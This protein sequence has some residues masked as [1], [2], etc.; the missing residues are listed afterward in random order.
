MKI[1]EI[2][3]NKEGTEQAFEL[4]SEV[5]DGIMPVELHGHALQY[6]IWDTISCYR[7]V[8]SLL[9]DLAMRPEF[10]H[11]IAARFIEVAEAIFRQSEELDLLDPHQMLL[12]CTVACSNFPS[13]NRFLTTFRIFCWV[14][15]LRRCRVG[16]IGVLFERFDS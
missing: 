11:Q 9:M 4:A 6:S 1:P 5:F 10:M 7:G 13:N 8:D 15:K 3:Y 14:C 12:H 16:R 2:S